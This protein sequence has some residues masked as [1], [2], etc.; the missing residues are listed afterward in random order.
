[1][2]KIDLRQEYK[3]LFTASAK[4]PAWLDV[5]ALQYLMI[6]GRGD[7]N[8]AESFKQAVGTLYSVSYTLKFAWK[9]EKAIDYPVMAL[10]G[11]WGTDD[12][13]EFSLER[14]ADWK[15][16]VMILQPDFI[17]RPEIQKIIRRVKVKSDFKDFPEVRV[18]KFQEGKCAQVLHLGPYAAEGPTVKR[19][20]DFIA[21]AGCRLRGKHHEIYLGDPRRSAQEKLRTILRQPAA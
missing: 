4:A 9:K 18:E 8:S 10:E 1:M 20:H 13:R 17:P 15:W 14:K 16:T 3:K 12:M 2:K 7:P 11:L 5:P 6:D 21:A 19:L